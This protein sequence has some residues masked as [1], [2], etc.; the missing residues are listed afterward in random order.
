MGHWLL[1]PEHR[2]GMVVQFTLV[3]GWAGTDVAVGQLADTERDGPSPGS[4]SGSLYWR[5]SQRNSGASV[6]GWLAM[7]GVPVA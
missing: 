2:L 7:D 5:S 4:Y 1:P 6:L 3:G